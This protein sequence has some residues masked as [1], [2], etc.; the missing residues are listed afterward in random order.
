MVDLGEQQRDERTANVM[1]LTQNRLEQARLEEE[2]RRLA[3]RQREAL[4]QLEDEEVKAEVK[5]EPME[6]EDFPPLIRSDVKGLKQ[7]RI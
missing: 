7:T 6:E 2:H 4:E 5:T 1:E 3:D